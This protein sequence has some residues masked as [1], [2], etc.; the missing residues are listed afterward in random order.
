MTDLKKSVNNRVSQAVFS[1]G[2]CER[3]CW[4]SVLC[5]VVFEGAR[6]GLRG[7]RGLHVVSG[8]RTG[9]FDA[10]ILPGGLRRGDRA[11][12]TRMS[13]EN[14]RE[15]HCG[16]S[17]AVGKRS[18]VVLRGDRRSCNSNS[19][20]LGQTQESR[21]SRTAASGDEHY[22]REIA[23]AEKTASPLRKRAG[24]AAYFQKIRSN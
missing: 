23:I 2:I 3:P 20:T 7:K 10:V 16:H 1:L 19:H 21:L 24:G 8:C 15:L 13:E 14:R 4:E 9:E 18:I 12:P 5:L 11:R 6:G 17:Q 22:C